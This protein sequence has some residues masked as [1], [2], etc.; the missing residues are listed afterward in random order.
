MLGRIFY[1]ISSLF[2]LIGTF[3]FLSPILLIPDLIYPNRID[4]TYISFHSTLNGNN[5]DSLLLTPADVG[6]KFS[7]MKIITDD[8]VQLNGWYVR[9]EDSLANTILLFHDLN[10]SKILYIDHLKQFHDR[11][12]NVCA[13]DLRAHGN[14]GGNEFTP[15][16]PAL[17]DAVQMIDSVMAQKN[18]KH[19]VIMGVG[20]GAAIALQAAVYDPQCEVLIL[21][22]PFNTYE[23]YIDRYARSKWGIMNKIWLPVLKRR[24]EELLEYPLKELDLMEITTYTE[25]PSLFIIGSDDERVYTSE[26]LQ[27]YD[28]SITEKK[29]LFLVRNEGNQN[30]AKAGGEIY[31]NRIAAFI[32]ST[33][34]KEQKKT[35][36][37]KL[38]LNDF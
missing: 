31:Y 38:A 37:K 25:V 11:G 34:P 4:S 36:Y 29:E 8:D 5:G 32:N 15:G 9:T 19:L 12:F 2:F 35:R 17:N 7:E 3:I 23:N 6:L 22:S 30:I 1:F 14:S 27:V 20:V 13:F 26:T 28:A 24:A 10:E 16:L 18:T 21:Q 33:L